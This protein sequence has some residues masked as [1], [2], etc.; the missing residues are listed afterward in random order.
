MSLPAEGSGKKRRIGAGV[1]RPLFFDY[2]ILAS[3]GATQGAEQ[4]WLPHNLCP[5]PIR[6]VVLLGAGL[7]ARPWRLDLPAGVR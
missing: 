2:I 7:D 4:A 5:E 1:V 3:C 6:Q